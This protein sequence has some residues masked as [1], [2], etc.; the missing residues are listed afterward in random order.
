MLEVVTDK[1][2]GYIQ[3][4]CNWYLHDFAGARTAQ[5]P[6]N[7]LRVPY[8]RGK[9]YPLELAGIFSEPFKRDCELYASLAC[10]HLMDFIDYYKL[11]MFEMFAQ[12]FPHKECL[13]RLRCCDEQIRR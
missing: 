13:E 6:G 7:R 9:T 12:S 10:R 5:E 3:L 4:F 1:T 2:D 8:G 11:H